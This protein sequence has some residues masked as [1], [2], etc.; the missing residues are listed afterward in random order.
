M[1]PELIGAVAD[2]GCFMGRVA[3]VES[4]DFAKGTSG[5][6]LQFLYDEVA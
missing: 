5:A 4:K 6:G 3:H 2:K 1:D